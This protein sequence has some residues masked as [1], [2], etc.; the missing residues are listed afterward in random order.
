MANPR[1][2]SLY[3]TITVK[4]FGLMII[5]HFPQCMD[6]LLVGE[7]NHDGDL[8]FLKNAERAWER[9]WNQTQPSVSRF[10]ARS[11]RWV[12]RGGGI[13]R[14]GYFMYLSLFIHYISLKNLQIYKISK[15][16]HRTTLI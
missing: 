7:S 14:R 2:F 4:L 11:G 3:F 10:M 8:Y 1:D 15:Y 6:A 9:G 5:L 16:I 13:P 12:K